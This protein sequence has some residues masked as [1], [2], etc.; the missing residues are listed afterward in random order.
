MLSIQLKVSGENSMKKCNFL[1][2]QKYHLFMSIWKDF[3]SNIKDV[4][5]LLEKGIILGMNHRIP[6]TKK[7]KSK[8]NKH[9]CKVLSTLPKNHL[10]VTQSSLMEKQ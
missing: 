9:L 1:K 4:V 3:N 8:E 2:K 10:S 7:I 5:H 6:V